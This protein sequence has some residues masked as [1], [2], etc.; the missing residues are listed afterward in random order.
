MVEIRIFEKHLEKSV[1]RGNIFGNL[2]L[3]QCLLKPLLYENTNYGSRHYFKFILR[4]K[5]SITK[6]IFIYFSFE[7]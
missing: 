4:G 3:K 5:K 7:V 6:L 2:I 1:S